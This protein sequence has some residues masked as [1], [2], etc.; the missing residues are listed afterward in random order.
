[1]IN[2]SVCDAIERPFTHFE[3]RGRLLATALFLL[4]HTGHSKAL[5]TL[6]ID[7]EDITLLIERM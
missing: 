6:S 2:T 4:E 1:M 7:D 5:C 3:A